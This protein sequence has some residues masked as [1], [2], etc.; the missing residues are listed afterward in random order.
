M[1]LPIYFSCFIKKK[2]LVFL[3]FI[4]ALSLFADF[5]FDLNLQ[6]YKNAEFFTDGLKVEPKLISSDK[7]LG[8][9]SFTLNDTATSLVIKKEGFRTHILDLTS[10]KN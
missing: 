5:A 7:T 2:L 10:I 3:F 4:S 8:H 6:P 9:L 1:K